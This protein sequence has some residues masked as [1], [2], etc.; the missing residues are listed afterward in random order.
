L[1]VTVKVRIVAAKRLTGTRRLPD[2]LFA[3]QIRT[4]D[5]S[6]RQLL[7]GNAQAAIF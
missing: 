7:Q 3:S 5:R 2:G 4:K 1:L 6:V